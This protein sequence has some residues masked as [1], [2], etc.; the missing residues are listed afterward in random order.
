MGWYKMT[1]FCF[2]FLYYTGANPNHTL[3]SLYMYNTGKKMQVSFYLLPCMHVCVCMFYG[4]IC[5]RMLY[6]MVSLVPRPPPRFYLAA[7]ENGCKIKSRQRPG[8]EATVRYPHVSS[9]FRVSC[10][11]LFVYFV[12]VI[13]AF[14]LRIVECVCVCGHYTPCI[15]HQLR[16]C[17]P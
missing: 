17:S 16:F 8:N 7:V 10:D 3:C 13:T 1:P 15:E 5:R 4:P 11:L 12:F 6:S 2:I 9:L 14:E